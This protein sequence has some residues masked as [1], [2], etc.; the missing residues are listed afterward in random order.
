MTPFFR[1]HSSVGVAPVRSRKSAG[2]LLKH[3]SLGSDVG[4]HPVRVL[5]RHQRGLG[6]IGQNQGPV[7]PVPAPV[8][9][10]EDV[11]VE[12]ANLRIVPFVDPVPGAERHGDHG[13]TVRVL[14]DVAPTGAAEGV[15]AHVQR[16]GLAPGFTVVRGALNVGHRMIRRVMDQDEDVVVQDSES[17]AGSHR[18]LPHG[19]GPAPI[20]GRPEVTAAG[21]V[22]VAVSGQAG[23]GVGPGEGTGHGIDSG[24]LDGSRGSGVGNFVGKGDGNGGSM[25][26]SAGAGGSRGHSPPHGYEPGRGGLPEEI[27]APDHFAGLVSMGLAAY[28]PKGLL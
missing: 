19:P 12:T 8:P 14:V 11:V 13:G 5:H 15:G 2:I 28:R 27:P 7:S 21:R 24:P 1:T 25:V 4:Q 26:A 10:A 6:R 18:E 3:G 16:K 17:A 23:S 9:G 20:P 22:D